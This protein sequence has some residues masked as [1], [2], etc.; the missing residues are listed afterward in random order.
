[1]A[2]EVSSD[3]ETSVLKSELRRAIIRRIAALEPGFRRSE[4]AALIAGFPDLPGFAS[5]RTV[6]LFYSAFPEEIATS[7]LFAISYA[8]GKSVCCPR[9][10][11][12]SRAL[13]L[14]RVTDPADELCPGIRGIPEP[15]ADL[16]EV[17]PGELDWVLVPGLAFDRRGFRLGR[18]A[19]HY[20]RLLP[21]L[22]PDTPC[23]SL[24]LSCQVVEEL[25]VEPHD[26]PLDGFFYPGQVVWGCRRTTH[27]DSVP[28]TADSPPK[29]DQREPLSRP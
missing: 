21:L 25:P 9:V 4:E 23:W 6:H 19:G 15:R 27:I 1:V 20:D 7:E 3:Q 16:V 5:A 29:L 11:R 28:E 17:K 12:S 13:R 14:H 10:D 26:A 18:G 2:K 24:C 22:R 8:M